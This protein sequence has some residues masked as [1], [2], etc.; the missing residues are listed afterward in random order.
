MGVPEFYLEILRSWSEVG[1]L[2]SKETYI[3]YNKEIQINNRPILFEPFLNQRILKINDL[4]NKDGTAKK[5]ND[6]VGYSVSALY[7]IL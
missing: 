4:F 5:F 6:W 7:H 2:S 3:W 1:Q